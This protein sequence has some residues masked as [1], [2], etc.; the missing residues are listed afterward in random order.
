MSYDKVPFSSVVAY[1]RKSRADGE[2]SVEEVLAKHERIIQDYCVR[3]FGAELPQS[4]I[5]REVQ[6]GE[7][8]DARPVM[9]HLIRLIQDGEVKGVIVVDLQRLSR[10]DLIDIGT[11]SRLFQVTGCEIITPTRQYNLTDEYDRSFFEMEIMHGKDYLAYIKKIMARGREQSVRE[12]NY[13]GSIAPFGYNRVFI[14]KKPTLEINESEA[15]IVRMIFDW[16]TGADLLGPMRIADKLNDLGIKPRINQTW[17]PA[18]VTN[19]VINP[20]YCGKLRWNQRKTKSQYIDGEI[21]K[22]RPRNKDFI[23]SD[24]KHPPIISYDQFEKAVQARQSRQ[25][26]NVQKEKR[27]VNPL[28]GIFRCE[29]GEMMTWK[30]YY[31]RNTHEPT[32]PM[33]LCTNQKRCGCRAS[34][35]TPVLHAIRIALEEALPSYIKLSETAEKSASISPTLNSLQ[36]ELSDYKKKQDKLYDYLERGVYSEEIFI[37]R[38]QKIKARIDE[39]NRS[40]NKIREAHIT[41]EQ[42]REFVSNLKEAIDSIEDMSIPP[43]VKNKLLRKS[44]NYITY[45][46]E[47][48]PRRKYDDTPIKISVYFVI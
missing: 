9:Q 3:V 19:I 29:C 45:R 4:K 27:L 46:R 22:T 2:E 21:V 16:Y 14:N 5:L 39:I 44:I 34:Y 30:T 7:T 41:I 12:G 42:Y 28:S 6:S 23:L 26:E 11:L 17:T 24:G 40:I 1:L 8:I 43:D 32:E 47:R 33:F 38:S 48:S 20:V 15:A 25:H 18:A 10:G 37:E 31:T 36:K 35:I 13:I